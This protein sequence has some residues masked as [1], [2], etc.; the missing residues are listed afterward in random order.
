MQDLSHPLSAGTP[1]YPG[2][3][4]VRLDPHATRGADGYRVTEIG[5]GSHAGTHVDAPAHT[6]PEGKPVDALPLRRFDFDARLVD[7]RGLDAGEV[8]RAADLPEPDCDMLVLR[9]GWDD[10]WGTDRYY[11]HPALAPDAARWCADR[12]YDLGFDTVGP[13][14][15]DAVDLPAHRALLGA[16]CLLLENLTNLD[17]LPERFRI[18]AYPLALVGADASPVRAVAVLR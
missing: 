4:P 2:D 17:G 10:H 14:P 12:G 9:T 1:V 5:L 15:V 6:E 8:V 16:G 11:D 18:R 3:P 7:L 13:D